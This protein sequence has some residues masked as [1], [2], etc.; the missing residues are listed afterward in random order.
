MEL[1]QELLKL[2]TSSQKRP[3]DRLAESFLWT[4]QAETFLTKHRE[5]LKSEIQKASDSSR[6]EAGIQ[7][8]RQTSLP[9]TIILLSGSFYDLG[10]QIKNGASYVDMELLKSSLSLSEKRW[11]AAILAATRRRNPTVTYQVATKPLKMRVVK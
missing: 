7:I 9:N 8:V 1:N 6:L 10:A 11:D 4:S 5:G 2:V 3:Q